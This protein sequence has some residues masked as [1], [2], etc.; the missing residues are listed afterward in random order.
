M[1]KLER[2]SF[3]M[4]VKAEGDG[5]RFTGLGAVFGN[6]DFG[7]D[8]IMKGAFKQTLKDIAA[9]GR[10]VPIL[11]QHDTYEPI[12]YWENLKETDEGLMGDGVLLVDS[13]DRAK[14]AA[15]L[16]KSGAV[17]GLSI[18]YRVP[19]GGAEYDSDQDVRVLKS[20]DLHE[21]SVVTFPMND[22]ARI[23]AVKAADMSKRDLERV[24]TQ[25]AGL[26]RSV[27][28]T[29]MSEGYKGVQSMHDAGEDYDEI[30]M[31]LKQSI[32]LKTG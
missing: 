19:R 8:M 4:E 17:S 15:G 2:K 1:T 9:K 26:S 3:S 13:I 18:G 30:A 6:E 10:K 7:G 5:S 11:W 25:D 14:G 24:L 31:L 28:R 22:E 23:D 12:G 32:K 29:L 16:I 20:L 21:I 27:A